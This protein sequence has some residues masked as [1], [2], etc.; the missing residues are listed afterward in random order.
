[1][2]FSRIFAIF[3]RQIYLLKGNP[4]RMTSIFIWLVID[5]VQWGFITKYLG[6]F[7]QAAMNFITIVLGAVIMWDFMA[8]I[9]QGTMTAF[10]EDIWS[11]NFINY[12]ASPLKIGEYLTG[13]IM[14]SSVTTIFSLSVMTGI[15][16][17]AFG[18]N[19]LKIGIM[20]VPFIFILYVFGMAMGIFISGVIFRLGPSAEWI[21][22]PIPLMMSVFCGVFYPLSVLPVPMRMVSYILPPS[23][24]FESLRFIINSPG[25]KF[26]A[27]NLIAA[28]LLAV[29]YL[30][31]A[32]I[33]FRSVYRRNLRTGSIPRFSAEEV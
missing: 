33:F 24:I 15:A 27:L 14:T 20:L 32:F 12:F 5:I 1:M 7:G 29:A 25:G 4:T 6:V 21:G 18:Y 13:L 2:N 3:I 23:Y 8:R 19:V 10:M 17:I 28:G 30:S 31:L 11:Q 16:G 26:P 9:Q 22:W